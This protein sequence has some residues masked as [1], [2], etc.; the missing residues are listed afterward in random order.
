VPEGSIARKLE[1]MV[2]VSLRRRAS[3]RVPVSESK[4]AT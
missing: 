3:P 4:G 2:S 1:A